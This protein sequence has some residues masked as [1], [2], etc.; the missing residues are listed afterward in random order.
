M[1]SVDF[2]EFPRTSVSEKT[3]S[4]LASKVGKLREISCLI[5]GDND[6][7]FEGIKNQK[8]IVLA[9]PCQIEFNFLCPNYVFFSL[10]IIY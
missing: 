8:I 6:R 1:V 9:M 4:G 10:I 5:H 2:G 3:E 7:R